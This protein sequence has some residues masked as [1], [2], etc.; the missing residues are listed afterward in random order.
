[1]YVQTLKVCFHIQLQEEEEFLCAYISAVI[2]LSQPLRGRL[3]SEK[4]REAFYSLS[5]VHNETAWALA[6]TDNLVILL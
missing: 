1:M 4:L 2:R 3:S 5:E 6:K